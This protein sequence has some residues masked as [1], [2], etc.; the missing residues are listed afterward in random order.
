MYET[1]KEVVEILQVFKNVVF[2][3][4]HNPESALVR[5][6]QGITDETAFRGQLF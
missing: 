4:L 3:Y 6:L 2:W 1:G 5:L